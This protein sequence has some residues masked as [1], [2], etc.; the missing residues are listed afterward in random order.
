MSFPTYPSRCTAIP[1]Y[2]YPWGNEQSCK[3]MFAVNLVAQKCHFRTSH[4]NPVA[5]SLSRQMPFSPWHKSTMFKAIRTWIYGEKVDF[6]DKHKMDHNNVH[7]DALRMVKLRALT[8]KCRLGG[9]SRLRKD[10][11][12]TFLQDNA[13]PASPQSVRPSNV[14]YDALRMVELRALKRGQGYSR[15]RKTELITSLQDNAIPAPSVRPRPLKPMRPLTPFQR[16]V[17]SIQ[18]RASFKL[19]GLS[20]FLNQWKE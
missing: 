17:H 12:I 8:R 6:C 19:L 3:S 9:Y 13:M 1:V 7:C 11:L 14:H 5:P 2:T 20:K 10:G 15:L 16:F 4:A 18:I